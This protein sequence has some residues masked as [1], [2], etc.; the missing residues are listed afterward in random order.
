M[1]NGPWPVRNAVVGGV[2]FSSFVETLGIK[3][4]VCLPFADVVQYCCHFG[5][6]SFFSV[7]FI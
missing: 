2:K 5:M 6:I 4:N 7:L 3:L 1:L